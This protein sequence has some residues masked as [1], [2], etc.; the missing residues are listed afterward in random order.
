[1]LEDGQIRNCLKHTSPLVLLTVIPTSI[2]SLGVSFSAWILP[3]WPV[4]RRKWD[5]A[6]YFLLLLPLRSWHTPRDT[7]KRTGTCWANKRI[8]EKAGTPFGSCGPFD[9]MQDIMQFQLFFPPQTTHN[10]CN[11][12]SER[13]RGL[14]SPCYLSSF[15]DFYKNGLIFLQIFHNTHGKT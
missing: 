7:P 5:T 8:G 13:H 11:M 4:I 1:M 3:S 2:P 10:Y 12:R 14:W 9:V 15:E 6:L